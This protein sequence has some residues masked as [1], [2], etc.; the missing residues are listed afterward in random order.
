MNE[1]GHVRARCR[2][3][4]ISQRLPS[5]IDVQRRPILNDVSFIIGARPRQHNVRTADLKFE[6]FDGGGLSRQTEGENAAHYQ[7]CD[8]VRGFH[9]FYL[10]FSSQHFCRDSNL[11][12][13]LEEKRA[14]RTSLRG[15]DQATF[16]G[17]HTRTR[18]L[19]RVEVNSPWKYRITFGRVSK[20]FESSQRKDSMP[21]QVGRSG[22]GKEL[23]PL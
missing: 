19:A 14:E 10:L 5:G 7:P 18:D 12:F 21:E 9:G 4:E 23:L 11:L 2:R 8:D 1:I 17:K 3:H 6:S 13:V 16:W 15:H 22:F 20:R